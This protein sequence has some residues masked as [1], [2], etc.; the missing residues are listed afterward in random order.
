VIQFAEQTSMPRLEMA[1]AKIDAANAADPTHLLVAGRERPAELVYG[2]RMT[3]AL[4][5]LHPEA[6]ELLKVAVRAQHIRRWTVPRASYPMDRAGYLRWRNDLKRKHAEWAG[7]I[8]SDCG[9]SER[10][11]ARVASLIRKEN[12]KGDAEAQALED[13][14]SMVFLESYAED[15]ARKH[16]E[17]KVAA[18]L[19]KT[20]AKMSALGRKT[21]MGLDLA[22]PVRKL[23]QEALTASGLAAGDAT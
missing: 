16:D 17:A 19:A 21:A 5:R 15:F 22:P 3:A 6:S 12:L 2:E 23:L 10:E 13:V 20:L 4:S 8:L 14:A 11:I 1:Y 9:Y 7:A 18:I